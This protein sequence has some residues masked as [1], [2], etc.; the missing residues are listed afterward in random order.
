MSIFKPDKIIDRFDLLNIKELK[1]RGF[2]A[3]FID[4]DNTI[5]IPK[6]GNLSKQ[7]KE[8]LDNIKNNGLVPIIFSNSTKNRVN[9]LVDGYDIDA[10]YLSLKPL[11]FIFW[12][13][14]K[15]YNLKNSECVIIGDQLLTDIA[16]ANLSGA[17]GVF[18]KKLQEKDTFITSINRRFEKLIWRHILHEKM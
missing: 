6:T 1:D 14:C 13:I 2:K 12:I 4:I 5:A 9:R 16:C 18:C 17:Y 3:V 7:A 15:K 10:Y 8:F 11:P